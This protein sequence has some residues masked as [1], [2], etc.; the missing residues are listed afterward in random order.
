MKTNLKNIECCGKIFLNREYIMSYEISRTD[1]G[2][3]TRAR[4]FTDA[5]F[6]Y[7]SSSADA[8]GYGYDKASA[9]LTQALELV[10]IKLPCSPNGC[11]MSVVCRELIT[12]LAAKLGCEKDDLFAVGFEF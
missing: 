1:S 3:T 10:G 5:A 4:V 6:D 8:R 11:G 12:Y 9:A 2:T 7:L